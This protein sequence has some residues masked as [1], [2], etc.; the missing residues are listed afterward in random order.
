MK[1]LLRIRIEPEVKQEAKVVL[2]K[3]GIN[4][5]EAVRIYL[6]Q[7]VVSKGLPFTPS[8]STTKAPYTQQSSG[9]QIQN[10]IDNI[11]KSVGVTADENTEAIFKDLGLEPISDKK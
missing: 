7:I 8:L 11:E 4:L 5:S 9:I 6:N 1:T 3:L 2:N 10:M